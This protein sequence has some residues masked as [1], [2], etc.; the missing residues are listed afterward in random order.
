MFTLKHLKRSN[1]FR[2]SFRPSSG[3]S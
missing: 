3:S 1:I 2:S